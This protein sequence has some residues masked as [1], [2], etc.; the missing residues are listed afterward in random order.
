[1][2]EIVDQSITEVMDL[3]DNAYV[4]IEELLLFAFDYELN[5]NFS[6][7]SVN[8]L[9]SRILDILEELAMSIDDCLPTILESIARDGYSLSTNEWLLGMGLAD[10]NITNVPS[11]IVEETLGE[12]FDSI[13]NVAANSY[14]S[15]TIMI[16]K[17]FS[18]HLQITTLN[19][20]GESAS[21]NIILNQIS[22]KNLQLY[23][24][25]N[26]VA[27]VDTS[28]RKW[29]V[30]TYIEML[31]KTKFQRLLIDAMKEF[32]SSTGYCDLA[33]IPHVITDDECA[34]FMGLIISLTG[35]TEGYHTYDELQAT[36]MIF[37]P[38]CRHT[39]IPIFSMDDLSEEERKIH[40]E[41]T[42]SI[43]MYTSGCKT[44]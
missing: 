29:K 1:M 44:K 21:A 19:N 22:G 43:K 12:I 18:Q 23:I 41:V 4:E 14:N 25:K 20:M 7:L 32:A 5:P 31:V 26:T 24:S 13:K 8:N 6:V 11:H 36:G 40:E 37:H 34:Y 33:K 38:R 27:I 2:R 42:N 39:P 10:G 17:V 9:K 28:G 30:H 16:D 35:A 3:Y 15:I